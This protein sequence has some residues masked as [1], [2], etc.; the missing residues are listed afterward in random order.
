MIGYAVFIP[1]IMQI[2]C[3]GCIPQQI[4]MLLFTYLPILI[5]DKFKIRF[6]IK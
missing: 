6:K 5:I 2:I 3:R 1:S 4:Y